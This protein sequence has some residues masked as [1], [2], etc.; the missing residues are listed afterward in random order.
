MFGGPED[1][2]TPLRSHKNNANTFYSDGSFTT[3]STSH[4]DKFKA[5]K[6]KKLIGQ[7]DLAILEGA[8]KRNIGVF[9]QISHEPIQEYG[10]QQKPSPIIPQKGPIRATKA[11]LKREDSAAE[12]QTN[13]NQNNGNE[14]IKDLCIDSRKPKASVKKRK[15]RN[16]ELY[17]DT[18]SSSKD[19][20][21]T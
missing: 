14:D 4:A 18:Q 19:P 10:G 16:E 3:T 11:A 6:N 7:G 12:S 20:S 21:Q 17:N 13:L 2:T 1:Q 8:N 5:F 9:S 15:G